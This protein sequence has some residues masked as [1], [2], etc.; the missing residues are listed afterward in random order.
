MK[1]EYYNDV[2]NYPYIDYIIK[3]YVPELQVEKK[4]S[5]V[6]ME[7]FKES[8]LH[9]STQKTSKDK[10]YE[11]L[12]YLGDAIF[13][14]IITEYFYK[15]YDDQNKGF[16]T[17]LRIK[18]ERGDSMAQLCRDLELHNY[19]K[20]S[21]IVIND[22]ILEDTFEA[23][24]GAFYLNFGMKYTR[25]FIVKMIEKHKD[26]S[27]LIYYDDNY[28]DILLR[29]FHK[30]KWGHP[31]YIEEKNNEN[32][33]IS[34]VKNSFGKILGKGVSSTKKKAEQLASKKA[35]EKVGIIIDNEIDP[36]WLNKIEKE[37]EE[38][39]KKERKTMSVCNPKNK[40][41]TKK[42][43]E[44]ILETYD[45]VLKEKINIKLF[46]EA[47]T[48]RS[49]LTRKNLTSEDKITLKKSVK[50][51]KKSNE[52][53]QF[54]GDAIIHFVIGEYIYQKYP[55]EDEG[56]L[57][58][59]RCK[60]ENR[61]S[62]FY[63]AKQSNIG[64]YLLVSQTI[65]LLHG[66][67]NVNII[68]GGFEAFVGALYL[69]IGLVKTREFILSVIRYELDIESIAE[70]ETNYKDLILQLYNENHWGHPIY[71]LIEESGP[72]HAKIFTMGIYLNNKL[73][74]KGT[75]SSKKKA[76]QIASKEMYDKIK[77]SNK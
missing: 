17:K 29:Y 43:I 42:E 27:S 11:R 38:I 23:F 40:L 18:I 26:L 73:M 7:F 21:G 52:R 57:T 49:Y 5:R 46:H 68:G 53:L 3:S 50:L 66:R 36:D 64:D 51:Q 32:K 34:L 62:L 10:T 70:N 74:G 65:E 2:I 48:H 9:S 35:L 69:D 28:K 12:E 16:L 15:R 1:R 67:N 47:M 22:H 58:R 63:L 6:N 60:L 14:M 56:F 41:L 59:L 25:I 13:H 55:L 19:I 44:N 45:V 75:A 20:I 4:N 37:D 30:M 71:K 33:F 61:E 31:K 54:L 72:D 8:M 77:S 24:V 39:D 76:E